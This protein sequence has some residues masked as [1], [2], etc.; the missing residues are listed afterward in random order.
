MQGTSIR[1][2]TD[3]E[4][5]KGRRKPPQGYHTKIG[6]SPASNVYGMGDYELY[7]SS[8]KPKRYCM[9]YPYIGVGGA[10]GLSYVGVVFPKIEV[11]ALGRRK[12]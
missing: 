7:G 2:R 4:S 10:G 9:A 6:Q 3:K 5:S 12:E 8:S 11:A 1:E